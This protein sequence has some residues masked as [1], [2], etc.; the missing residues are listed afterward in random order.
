M[1][2]LFEENLE[3][4]DRIA[5]SVR[6]KLP[7]SFDL[8]D[9]QQEARL[10]H[11]RCVQRFDTS[12]G[13]PY[14]AF[15]FFAV[16]G[17]V[18]MSCRRKEYRERTHE[19]LDGYHI[20]WRPRADQVVLEREE[21]RNVTGPRERRQLAKVREAMD[22]IPPADARLLRHVFLEG[23]DLDALEPPGTKRRLSAAVAR[24][25]QVVKSGRSAEG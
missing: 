12:Q 1:Q 24:L 4:A 16:R 6:R 5:R 19:E 13:V 25:R 20:D 22:R 8:A 2:A 18:L 9:L 21:R 15:A 14:R 17:A 3:W 11:W 23:A 10:Q 7:P